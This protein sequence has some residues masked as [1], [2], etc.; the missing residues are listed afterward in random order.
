MVIIKAAELRNQ[1]KI[2]LKET[3]SGLLKERFKLRLLTS[4]NEAGPTHKM[5]AVRRSIARIETILKE[6]EQK[7][8]G[9]HDE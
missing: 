8:K 1:S 5:K 6:N 3:L 7:A 9:T 2:E 4:G